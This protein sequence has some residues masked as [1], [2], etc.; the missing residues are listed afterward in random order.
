MF[1]CL[2]LR[3]SKK[4]INNTTR[5]D[6]QLSEWTME[7]SFGKFSFLP[8]I[9]QNIIV[10]NI[11]IISSDRSFSRREKLKTMRPKHREWSATAARQN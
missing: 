11:K 8:I 10:S 6:A 9:V 2:L 4:F 3:L 5:K 1:I 7:Y